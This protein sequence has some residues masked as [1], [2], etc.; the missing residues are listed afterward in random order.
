M[1]E[2]PTGCK[3]EPNTPASTLP[4]N[5]SQLALLIEECYSKECWQKCLNFNVDTYRSRQV[6]IKALGMIVIV[7]L[8]FTLFDIIVEDKIRGNKCKMK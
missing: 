3:G 2:A 1:L 7:I 5:V 8:A 4:K 6:Q